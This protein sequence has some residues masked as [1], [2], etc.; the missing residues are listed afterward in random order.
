[1]E[2]NTN[3]TLANYPPKMAV[4]AGAIVLKEKRVLFI[5]QAQ[6]QSLAGHWSIPWGVVE[7]GE[8]PEEAAIRETFEEAGIT[9]ETDG[10]L[11]I[12]NLRSA[13]WL[14]IIFIGRHLSGEPTPDRVETDKAAYFSW[15]DLEAIQESVEPWCMWIVKRVLAGECTITPCILDNPY[16]PRKAF[17]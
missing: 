12:Q 15:E 7:E 17:L 2:Q 3:Y 11:G 5:R 6:G 8:A 16:Q 13:G 4:C 9:M 10:L 14:G 1:M